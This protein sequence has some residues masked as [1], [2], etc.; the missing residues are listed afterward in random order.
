MGKTPLVSDDGGGEGEEGR[1]S[2]RQIRTG[3]L[4]EESSPSWCEAKEEAI[5]VHGVPSPTPQRTVDNG[6]GGGTQR[7]RCMVSRRS[8]MPS[9]NGVHLVCRW[10]AGTHHTVT[11]VCWYSRLRVI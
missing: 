5:R 6:A 10:K 9:S 4:L 8:Y 7:Q 1:I 11:R 2:S 3:G